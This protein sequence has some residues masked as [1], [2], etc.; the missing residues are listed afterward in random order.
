VVTS[1]STVAVALAVVAC[2]A[3]PPQAPL[4]YARKLGAA[5]SGI[6]TACGKAY[7]LTA[8]GGPHATGLDGL[9]TAASS[10]AHSLALVLR[11]D[12]AWI[13]QGETVREIVS[14]SVSLLG[15]CE[16]HDARTRLLRQTIQR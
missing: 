6:S 13:Y 8:F 7:L 15:S 2:G 4:A 14:D 5:T 3:E 1:L 9:E 11:R 10:S 16:L 12:P